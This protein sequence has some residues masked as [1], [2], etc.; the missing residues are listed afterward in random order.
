MKRRN[1]LFLTGG[2]FLVGVFLGT[3]FGEKSF[4]AAAIFPLFFFLKIEKKWILA[5]FIAFFLGIFRVEMA[6]REN[7]NFEKLYGKKIEIS[8]FLRDF[9]D[10]RFSVEKWVL[11]T[12][13]GKIL[14][15]V[16]RKNHLEV[17]D[18][19]I[20]RGVLKKPFS[21]A[22]FSYFDFLA[23]DEIFGILKFPKIK[24]TGKTAKMPIKKTIWKIREHFDRR[25]DARFFGAEK[26]FA[27]GILTGDRGDFSPAVSEN[28]RRTGLSH[29]L[30]LSGFNVTIVILALFFALFWLPTK[31]KIAATIL[32]IA[33]FVIFVGGGASVVRAAVMGGISLLAVHSGRQK[34]AF[35]I[36]MDAAVAMVAVSPLILAFDPSFQLS[37]AGTAGILA[38]GNFLKNRVFG[39]LPRFFSETLATTIAAQIGVFPL[40]GF[41]FGQ[42]SVVAPLSNLIVAP[43]IPIA[44]FLSFFAAIFGGFF[45]EFLAFLATT[46]LHFL[47]FA[48]AFLA[49]WKFS[50]VGFFLGKMLFWIFL[51]GVAAAGFWINRPL[52]FLKK[53]AETQK[54][55]AGKI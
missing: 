38:F 13:K 6:P 42:I 53:K 21:S 51:A 33:F 47:L 7:P 44:M 9:P 48:I 55:S 32:G 16:P 27:A 23:K 31:I 39:F 24:K 45:G 11:T 10:R 50:S 34:L 43:A 26:A 20:V 18:E 1:K 8:G 3:F 46:I 2:F 25:L 40:I 12:K 4:L 35:L 41:L 19:I 37:I 5:F 30:A 22:D 36:L 49:K 28:F 29:L 14:L 54:E 17:G 52:D 15:K